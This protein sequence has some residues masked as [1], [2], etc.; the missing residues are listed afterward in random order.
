[1]YKIIEN[2]I[3]D[4]RYELSDILMKI[5]TYWLQSQITDEEKTVLVNLAREHADFTM[6][7]NVLKMI[8]DLNERVTKLEN[9]ESVK[10]DEY[11]EYVIG[12]WY[13]K[14]DKITYKSEKY[15]CIAPDGQ[16]C[17]WNPEEYPTYWKKV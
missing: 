5:D 9:K 17:T 6:S 16:V 13:Y 2:V 12:K 8:E 3:L 4:G 10:P 1:M 11:P 14:D 15:I 7:L